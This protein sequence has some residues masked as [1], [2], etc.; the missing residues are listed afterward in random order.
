ME[1]LQGKFVFVPKGQREEKE[2]RGGQTDKLDSC[3]NL[4][5][6]KNEIEEEATCA[7]LLARLTP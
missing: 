6:A 3:V 1:K 5:G 4:G 2:E 7:S